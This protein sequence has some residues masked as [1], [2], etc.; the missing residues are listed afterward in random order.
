MDIRNLARLT[1]LCA[2]INTTSL[3]AQTGAPVTRIE[4]TPIQDNSFLIEEAYNQERGVVQHISTFV[5]STKGSDWTYAFT[6]EWPF[7]RQTHQLSYTVPVGRS[8]EGSTRGTGLGDIAVNYRY[9]IGGLEERFA[10]APRVSVLLPTGASR[11]ALGSGG[12]GFQVNL[13]F[14]VELPA[15]LVAHT[16]AG[17]TYTPRARDTFGNSAATR[18]YAVGQSVIWLAHPK[19]NL[20]LESIWTAAWDVTGPGQTERSTEFLLS[21]GVRGAIDFASGLQVVPGIAFPFGI[22]NSRGE[23]SV[24]AYLSFEHPFGRRSP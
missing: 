12:T 21:P 1:A 6:Q 15:R 13:P 16:N 2:F 17:G 5:H 9:Q 24:F 4:P 3:F 22:G 18:S 23:R 14:S 7:R 19:L 10:I 20:M 8:G 11:R